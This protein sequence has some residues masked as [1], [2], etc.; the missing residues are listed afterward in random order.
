MPSNP[1]QLLTVGIS[2]LCT[3]PQD[4]AKA[5][6]S[7]DDRDFSVKK[8]RPWSPPYVLFLRPEICL[9]QASKAKWLE[10]TSD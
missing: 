2:S 7:G 8:F 6:G 10:M 5:T 3:P 4:R 1:A 9:N